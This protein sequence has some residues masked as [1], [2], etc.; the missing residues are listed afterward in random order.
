MHPQAP[1]GRKK[2]YDICS[3]KVALF[4]IG[5]WKSLPRMIA[6]AIGKPLHKA[7][8]D[9]VKSAM[10]ATVDVLD[11]EMGSSYRDIVRTCLTGGFAQGVPEGYEELLAQAILTDI[12]ASL[13]S[14]KA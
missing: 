2:A 3:P 14:L 4:E 11:H 6:Q 1:S 5:L 12:I 10:L 7:S 8:V 9:E 13:S